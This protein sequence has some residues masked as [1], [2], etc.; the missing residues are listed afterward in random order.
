MNVQT[1]HPDD[2]FKLQQRMSHERHAEQR[3]RYRAVLLA[4]EGQLTQS[5]SQILQRSRRFV[6]RWVYAYRDHGIDAIVAK[7][8]GGSKAKLDLPQ[9]KQLIARF[10]AGPT[11]VDGGKCT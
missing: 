2:I 11:Q 5:I 10:K 4:L 8:R 3:D 1:H 7:P 9:Q 6:Q